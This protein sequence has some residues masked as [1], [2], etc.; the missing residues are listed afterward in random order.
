MLDLD[1]N[2]SLGQNTILLPR[3]RRMGKRKFYNIDR[4]SAATS[5]RK[6]AGSGPKP[7]QG[8][9]E[10]R[11]ISNRFSRTWTQRSFRFP[12]TSHTNPPATCSRIRRSR[13]RTRWRPAGRNRT[14]PVW[15]SFWWSRLTWPRM[16]PKGTS[17]SWSNSL[18]WITYLATLGF[19]AFSFFWS[20]F[21]PV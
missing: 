20:K 3:H 8:S 18:R 11:K 10:T 2:Y 17:K 5:R 6:S 14:K 21:S 9:S 15:T 4:S 12:K 7:L 1:E 19:V 16:A 13:P